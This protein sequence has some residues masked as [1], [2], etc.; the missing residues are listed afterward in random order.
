MKNFK[1]K[2]YL[3]PLESFFYLSIYLCYFTSVYLIF[4]LK[5]S[6]IH[7][8]IEKTQENSSWKNFNMKSSSSEFFIFSNNFLATKKLLKNYYKTSFVDTLRELFQYDYLYFDYVVVYLQ[9]VTKLWNLAHY[10]KS[11]REELLN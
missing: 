1:W 2:N 10:W 8:I 5:S 6:K 9:M 11:S 3:Y 7:Y 4:A